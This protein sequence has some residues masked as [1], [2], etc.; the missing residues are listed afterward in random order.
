MKVVYLPLSFLA[1]CSIWP[2]ANS[3]KNA[4]EQFGG[5]TCFFFFFYHSQWLKEATLMVGS[6]EAGQYCD[7]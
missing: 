1:N 3:I 6:V 5:N 7:N 4:L 2:G